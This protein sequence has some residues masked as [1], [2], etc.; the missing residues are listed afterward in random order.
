VLLAR[1]ITASRSEGGKFPRSAGPRSILKPGQTLL[2]KAVSPDPDG[3][4]ITVELG[5]DLKVAGVILVSG[6]KDQS[7]PEG[8]DLRRGTSSNQGL[9]LSALR[10]CQ[11]NGLCE[12]ERHR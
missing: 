11:R 9:Q 2:Q 4:A 8:Q 6:S 12:W 5:G 3:V 1:E 10:V 7:A